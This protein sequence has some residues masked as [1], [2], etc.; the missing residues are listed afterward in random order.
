MGHVV[1]APPGVLCDPGT[2]PAPRSPLPGR[3]GAAGTL[4]LGSWKL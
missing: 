2:T 4:A 1:G 3:G